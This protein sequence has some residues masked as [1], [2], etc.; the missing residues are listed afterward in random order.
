MET[1][2]AVGRWV[3]ENG[4]CNGIEDR[5]E[6]DTLEEAKAFYDESDIEREYKTFYRCDWRSAQRRTF[7]KDLCEVHYDEDGE[8]IDEE[9]GPIE[10]AEFGKADMED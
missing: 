4:T 9:Y 1:K 5:H 10:Y 7:V 8:L 6:F 2:Y 3:D